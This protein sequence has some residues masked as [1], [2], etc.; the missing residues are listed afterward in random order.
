MSLSLFSFISVLPDSISWFISSCFG[1][2][3]VLNLL[4]FSFMISIIHES[5]NEIAIESYKSVLVV[6]SILKLRKVSKLLLD[7]L[8]KITAP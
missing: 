4:I 8:S 7:S 1:V 3:L 6:F 5:K 2:S